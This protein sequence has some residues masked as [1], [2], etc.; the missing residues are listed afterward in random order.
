MFNL[1]PCLELICEK[2]D[3][4]APTLLE[5]IRKFDFSDDFKALY[6][7]VNSVHSNIQKNFKDIMEKNPKVTHT[8]GLG[9]VIA[10]AFN[11][12]F[13]VDLTNPVVIF[14]CDQK[15]IKERMFLF[16]DAVAEA[17][18]A[19]VSKKPVNRVK[20]SFI[21]M[22]QDVE[23]LFESDKKRLKKREKDEEEKAREGYESDVSEEI[24]DYTDTLTTWVNSSDS[25]D[26]VE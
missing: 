4:K 10:S 16:S 24:R 21:D 19:G 14:K 11:F 5:A 15:Y 13:H 23:P 20:N 6:E 18:Q 17:E 9:N 2:R 22:M 25:L 12:I 26:T 7:L 1:I 3:S 8:K